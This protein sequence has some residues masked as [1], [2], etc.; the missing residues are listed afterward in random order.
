[1]I[2]IYDE[3][4]Y[5]KNVLE[6][7]VSDKWERDVILLVRYFKADGIKKSEVK[8]RMKE[9]CEMAAKR[10]VNPIAYNHLISYARLNKI[11][12][13]AWKKQV[14]L[15]EI[16]YIDVSR[17]VVNWFLNLENNFTLE[18]DRLEEL[19]QRRPG[20]N[21]KK[22]HPI[23]W[24]RT[25]YLWTLY[26]WTRVQENYLERPNMHYLQ[27]YSK[28]FK[29]DANLK[30]SF[31]LRRERDFL[32]DLGLIDVNYALGIDTKFIRDYDVFKIPITDKNRIRIET[33][34]PPDGELYNCGYWLEKQKMG[35]FVCQS[36]GKTFAN[37]KKAGKGRPRKYCKECSDKIQ[38]ANLLNGKKTIVCIDCGLS[39]E[40][41]SKDNQ[42]K[43]CPTCYE[44]YR[45]EKVRLNMQK[46]RKNTLRLSA[47]TEKI[48]T[49]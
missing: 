24:Q 17:E 13:G 15:R 48:K 18:E 28:R 44:L 5:I 37:Y 4:G 39:F 35:S 47:Q 22:G 21:I 42:T 46:M 34:E 45:N 36:C 26:I 27:K 19:R 25:K 7:G 6:N 1:M 23:N 10:S 41:S 9:K 38:K 2:D 40:V 16:K 30:Q 8:R 32:Y 43:R 49:L 14:P 20:I 29:E 12:D 11:I 3:I 31:N 33:G